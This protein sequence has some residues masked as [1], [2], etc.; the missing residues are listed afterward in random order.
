MSENAPVDQLDGMALSAAV[1][2]EVMGWRNLMHLTPSYW[3]PPVPQAIIE[4]KR[5]RPDR[6]ANQALRVLRIISDKHPG[7]WW[8]ED[9]D[10]PAGRYWRCGWLSPDSG[11]LFADG[12]TL[13]L[14]ICRAALV[15]VRDRDQDTEAAQ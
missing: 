12:A 13:P 9:F 14:A 2:Q 4:K 3:T 5:W 6:N 1:A 8:I 10:S 11:S 7:Y 15:V